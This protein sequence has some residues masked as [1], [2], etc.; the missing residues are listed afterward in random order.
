MTVHFQSGGIPPK[1]PTTTREK[2]Q[3][4]VDLA[5]QL[6]R[7]NE[8]VTQEERD[9]RHQWT[10]PVYEPASELEYVFDH[11]EGHGSDP[12][13]IYRTYPTIKA[14]WSRT[15]M[16]CGKKEYTQK[17]KPSQMVPDFG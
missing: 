11:F 2:R 17:Q 1:D 9:C 12:E 6:R 10:E 16:K 4:A 15:C 7:L 5:E 14:R 13:P 3:R 8:E